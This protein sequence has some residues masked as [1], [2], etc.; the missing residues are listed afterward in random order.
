ERYGFLGGMS[1]LALVYPWMTFHTMN[2]EQ[3]IAGLAE[4]IVQ[5]LKARGA[6]PGHLRDTVG[7]THTVTPYD[8]EVY[9]LVAFE[10]LEEAGADLLLHSTLLAVHAQEGTVSSIDVMN[11]AGVVNITGSIFIDTTGDGDL[12]VLAG[13]PYA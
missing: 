13:A 2:G 8:P 6:S 1:T 3:V 11:K 10:L 9:K 12:A 4:E 5:R 7:F